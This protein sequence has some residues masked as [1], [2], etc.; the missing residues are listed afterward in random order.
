MSGRFIQR[1][2]MM[3]MAAVAALALALTASACGAEEHSG[4]HATPAEHS[5]PNAAPDAHEECLSK[6][7]RTKVPAVDQGA[8]PVLAILNV[9]DL[10]LSGTKI[11]FVHLFED[12]QDPLVLSFPTHERAPPISFLS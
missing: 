6:A 2:R 12:I 8:P 3:R 4:M 10:P 7:V 9:L 1:N 5:Q 11:L